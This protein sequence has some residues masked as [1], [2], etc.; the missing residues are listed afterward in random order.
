MVLGLAHRYQLDSD[1]FDD[2][3]AGGTY[4]CEILLTFEAGPDA[5]A[6]RSDAPSLT[7]RF[8]DKTLLKRTD[9]IPANRLV[10]FAAPGVVEGRNEFFVEAVGFD[11]N[12]DLV[13]ALQLRVL[14]DR[15]PIAEKWLSSA[16]GEPVVGAVMV[17]VPR[18]FRPSSNER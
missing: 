6:G 18:S 12:P 5:F 10:E 16:P 17:E 7:V 4:T 3:V 1:F 15:R 8:R 11:D 14:R 13:R 9:T 2:R